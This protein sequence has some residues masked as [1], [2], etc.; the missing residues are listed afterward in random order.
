LGGGFY[1][2]KE[3]LFPVKPGKAG[4]GNALNWEGDV[5]ILKTAEPV[6]PFMEY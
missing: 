6:K 4:Y 2:F 3:P 1:R 5:V